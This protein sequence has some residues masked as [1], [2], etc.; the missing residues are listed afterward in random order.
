[1]KLDII[2]DIHGC[3][4]EFHELTLKL[5]YQWK[6]EIPVYPE[7]RKLAFVGDITDRGPQSLKMIST[8]Y[9]LIQKDLAYY[10]PGNHC[11]K[12]Y[13]YFLGNKVQ[14]THG[15]ETTVAEF[16]ALD[17]KE[18]QRMR[19]SFIQLYENAPL[20]HILAEGKLVIAHAGI[21]EELIGKQNSRAPPVSL[22][23]CRLRIASPLAAEPGPTIGSGTPNPFRN[24]K[25]QNRVSPAARGEK[26]SS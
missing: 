21:S 22:R 10:V 7:E 12:L 5:G 3:F 11:N 2:G 4:H 13:R 1:M 19:K 25:M 8:V 9:H 15:L 6:H 17:K 20:Y 26:P 23:G 14:I 18:Q 16:E 24:I